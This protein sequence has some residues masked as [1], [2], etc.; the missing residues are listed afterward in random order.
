MFLDHLYEHYR[1]TATFE[2][3]QDL[4]S[5]MPQREV[6]SPHQEEQLS[7]ILAQMGSS[8]QAPASDTSSVSSAQ[9]SSPLRSL[10]NRKRRRSQSESDS[11]D[12]RPSPSSFASPQHGS[13]ARDK[14]Q[15]SHVLTN[16]LDSIRKLQAQRRNTE[17]QLAETKHHNALLQK[18]NIE[19]SSQLRQALADKQDFKDVWKSAQTKASDR[20]EKVRI[21]TEQNAA[22]ETSKSS[23]GEQ[24]VALEISTSSLEE[25]NDA[26]E[27]S[28]SSLE[29]QN[30]ALQKSNS[31]LK[32]QLDAAQRSN[33]SLYQ[34]RRRQDNLVDERNVPTATRSEV[35]HR[36]QPTLQRHVRTAS[37]DFMVDDD[38]M[39][40]AVSPSNSV[41]DAQTE[42]ASEASSLP[43]ADRPQSLTDTSPERSEDTTMSNNTVT[44][45][46]PNDPAARQRTLQVQRLRGLFLLAWKNVQDF[47]EDAFVECLTGLFSKG[48]SFEAICTK[49]DDY[50]CGKKGL[51]ASPLPCFRA[52]TR[53]NPAGTGKMTKCRF[54]RTR[55]VCYHAKLATGVS[56]Q[57]DSPDQPQRPYTLNIGGQ[58]F[59]WVLKKR[60]N[61]GE[62]HDPPYIIGSVTV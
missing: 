38:D 14:P 47:E 33:A 26:L 41:D 53:N 16:A 8:P 42:S 19:Q 36:E 11:D 44:V 20:K 37:P 46:T 49:I 30:A 48:K 35:L 57:T 9:D 56:N 10:T 6:L 58:R 51:K 24:N 21:F 39:E 3:V 13:E 17:R 50:C 34:E 4:T 5:K 28:K 1:S 59:R 22:L 40:P 60:R 29:G 2:S 23:L 54:C 45:P 18:A 55:F 32:E 61:F 25:Q 43:F 15:P 62:D 31:S 27:T 7:P 52:Y 12:R